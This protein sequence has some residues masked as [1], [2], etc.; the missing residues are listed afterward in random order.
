MAPQS[1]AELTQAIKTELARCPEA[2]FFVAFRD[3]Q[4]P[5][6]TVLINEKISI[7]PASTM[8][9]PVL[10]EVYKQAN[11]GKFE[12]G[13]SL[14]VKNEFKSIVDGSPYSLQASDDSDLSLY[15]VP[16]WPQTCLL[17]CWAR[18]K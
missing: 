15:A 18:R 13:D 12:L 4:K 16:I 2:T 5:A 14:T 1:L 6:Q 10:V 11:E 9:T 17:N 3:L 7:H 8:K